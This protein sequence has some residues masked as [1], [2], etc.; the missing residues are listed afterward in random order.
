MKFFYQFIFIFLFYAG[1]LLSQVLVSQRLHQIISES[2]SDNYV[3]ALILLRDQVDVAEL[4]KR[5]YVQRASIEQRVFEV[6]TSLKEKAAITQTNLLSYLS[7]RSTNGDVFQYQSFWI[8]NLVMV[9]AKPQVLIELMSRMDIAEMDIDALLE[10]DRPVDESDAEPESI[11]SVEPGIKIINAHLLW[12]LGITGQGRLVMGHDTGVYPNHPA[13]NHKWRG[14]FV[15]ANQAWFDPGGGTTTPND[16]DSHGSH[17]VGT[18]VGRSLTTADTIGVAIDAQWIAA[19]TICTSPHTSN[20]IAAFQW[21]L[22]PDGNPS[23]IN[24]MPDVISCSW[25]DPNSTD[26]CNQNNIYRTT[27]LALE[28]AGIAVVF[29]A[30]NSG[31]N[32]S[33]ITAPKNINSNETLIFS[34]GA[35]DGA[36]Y[37]GGNN[38]PI[39]NFSSRGPSLCGGTGSLLIKPEVSAPGVSVRS[40]GTATGYSVKSGTSM[41][42]PHVAGAVALLKQ[43]VPNLTGKQIL[44]ALYFTA[45]DLGVAGEDNNYGMGLIDVYAAYL[46][47][48]AP[49]TTP[50]NPITNLSVL[51]PTS[52]SLSLQWTVPYDSSSNGVTGYDIRYSLLPITDLNSFNNAQ[53][54][55]FQGTPGNFGSTQNITVSGLSFNTVYYFSV[56]STDMFGNWSLLSNSAAGTTWTAPQ[57]SVEPASITKLVRPETVYQDTI[58]ITNINQLP[59]TLDFSVTL[60]NNNFPDGLISANIIPVV[61]QQSYESVEKDKPIESFGVSLEGQGGPDPFGYSWIDSNDPN[62]PQYQWEDITATGTLVTNWIATGTFDPKDEGYAGPFQLGFNFNFYGIPKSQIYISSNGFLH[63]SPLTANAF[64]NSVIPS[65]GIPNDI[66]APFWDDLDGSGQGTVHYKQDGNRFIIQFTNWQRYSKTGTLTFQAVLYSNGRIFFYYN[67]MNTTLNSA[68]IGIENSDGTVGLQVVYNASYVTN[69]L[70]V[71]ISSDPEWLSANVISGIIY[72]GN[73]VIVVLTFSSEDYQPGTYSMDAIISSNDPLN[74]L[75]VVPVT[76]ELRQFTELTSLK[77]LIH[78][79]YDGI[80]MVPDTITVELRSNIFPY[81]K[82]D[83]TKV[84]L[85]QSGQ[86]SGIFLNAENMTAYYIIVKH[87]N[88]LETWS[89]NAVTISSNQLSYDFTT[90]I[91]KAFGNNLVNKAGKWCIYSGDVNGDGFIDVADLN[92]VFIDNIN[93]TEGYIAT[94]LNGDMITEIEDVNI[95]FQ[96]STIGVQVKR[97]PDFP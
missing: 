74:P 61:T 84:Y 86:G 87:R 50:P 5:F 2:S 38:N 60:D 95:V 80:S 30:G 58:Y 43:A 32:A 57:I 18:M 13:L 46:S 66:I 49:D 59:S 37:Q 83:E 88:A 10:L 51:S 73:S 8:S 1:S 26:Q 90:G 64:T 52:N 67:N 92:Q 55:P 56:R 53:Q 85:N 71:K 16:C 33:T 54:I 82:V 29:S 23:T 4:D 45:K 11:E 39:A 79:L 65:S 77:V 41:A 89:S 34:V 21:A 17:T 15:P 93:G 12:Q 70:A 31:P 96:N 24:D 36:S 76:M 48:A 72:S 94:D 63:F 7:S 68:T 78:G 28:A 69:G 6:I 75:I 62:G 40:S 22:N 81:T 27:L 35:I 25:W 3:R 47:L 42:A 14:N 9:E 44:E 20:S 19:K 97:P 91:D